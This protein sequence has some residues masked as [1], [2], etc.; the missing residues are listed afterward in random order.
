M[1]EYA[2]PA[3]YPCRGGAFRQVGRDP[4]TSL[5]PARGGFAN[6]L[7]RNFR[8]N[9]WIYWMTIPVVVYYLVFHYLPMIGIVI[10]FQDY[11]PARGFMGSKWV[12]LQ[13]F[14][15]FFSGPFAGRLIRNTVMINVWSL[16]FGFPAPILLALLL[17][18]IKHTAYKRSIQTLS[19]LPHFISLVVICGMLKEFSMTTGLFNDILA[20]LGF[21]PANLLGEAQL[22]RSVYVGSGIWQTIGWGSIIYLATLAGADPNLY[23]A[24]VIDG[25]NRLQRVIHITFPTLMPLVVMQL[26]LRMGQMMNVGH[27]KIILLYSPLTYETADVI[28]SYIY[29]R[30]LQESKYSLGVAIGLFNALINL[31]LVVFSNWFSNRTVQEGLW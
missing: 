28:S 23:E 13:N 8:R 31:C 27:E 30:G 20:V 25:A 18:E 26:I 9:P 16:L 22:F 10:A 17:N 7:R 15:D 19:Y 6:A 21:S 1:P 3:A 12:G 24:A 5:A 14:R 4:M 2:C 11:R 29:R